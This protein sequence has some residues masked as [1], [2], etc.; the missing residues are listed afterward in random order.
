[1]HLLMAILLIMPAP[2]AGEPGAGL[3]QAAQKK[4]A[5]EQQFNSLV[6][7]YEQKRRA[8]AKA[9]AVANTPQQKKDAEAAQPSDDEYAGRVLALVQQH[10][11]DEFAFAALRWVARHANPS[12]NAE[13]AY[14]LL[15]TDHLDQK[16][17]AEI[18]ERMVYS[19]SPTLEH[20]LRA[21]MDKS[22]Q[23]DVR[24]VA[25]LSLARCLKMKPEQMALPTPAEVDRC[26]A[27]AEALLKRVSAEYGDVQNRGV[28][29]K[30]AVPG[31][32]YEIDHLSIGQPAPEILGRDID[33]RAFR[34]SDYRGKVVML[35]FWGHW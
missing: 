26:N 32:L 4:E 5:P 27:E 30:A 24:A 2:V 17:M 15:F 19:G 9:F 13:K 34:L 10:R 35:D 31:E 6:K 18:A 16:E 28:S 23:R 29:L 7:E 14:E 8:A 20:H 12:A 1:M 21:L 11:T 25:C 22:P 3:S 33:G